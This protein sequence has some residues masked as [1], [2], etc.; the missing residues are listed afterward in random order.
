MTEFYSFCPTFDMREEYLLVVMGRTRH[1]CGENKRFLK[2]IFCGLPTITTP[3]TN[4][5]LQSYLKRSDE[6]T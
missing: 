4:L 1:Y 6:W 3:L 2:I 5:N